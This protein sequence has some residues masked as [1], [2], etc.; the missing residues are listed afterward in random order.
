MKQQINKYYGCSLSISKT[1]IMH[2]IFC[3]FIQI[4]TL[5]ISLGKFN[6]YGFSV[7]QSDIIIKS[8][9]LLILN[10]SGSEL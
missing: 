8:S 4:R 6:E 1:K 7:S 3:K 5:K 9:L 2:F 10:L